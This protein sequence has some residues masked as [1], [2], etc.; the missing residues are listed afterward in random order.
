MKNQIIVKMVKKEKN[1]EESIFLQS[2]VKKLGTQFTVPEE[3]IMKQFEDAVDMFYIS[4]G[5]CV[6]NY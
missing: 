2:L 1:P 3:E 4:K 6:I 5:D